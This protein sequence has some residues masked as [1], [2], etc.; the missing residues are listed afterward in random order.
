MQ[1]SVLLLL[2]C[3]IETVDQSLLH[4]RLSLHSFHDSKPFT[5][6]SYFTFPVTFTAFTSSTQ[7]LKVR[8]APEFRVLLYLYG[9]QVTSSSLVSLNTIFI[10]T[11]LQ[12]YISSLDLCLNSRFLY[13]LPLHISIAC[14][15]DITNLSCSKL[16]PDLS[17]KIFPTHSFSPCKE[18]A[19]HLSSFLGHKP[20]SHPPTFFPSHTL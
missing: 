9:L 2:P 10:L 13:P 15:K 11:Y 16:T 17:S 3:N 6:S 1:F 12:I 4:E 20:W 19:L 7:L 5:I 18:R 8:G 14:P